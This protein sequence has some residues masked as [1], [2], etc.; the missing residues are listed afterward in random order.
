MGYRG[1]ASLK[2]PIVLLLA[3]AIGYDAMYSNTDSQGNVA[4]GYFALRDS[5]GGS[6]RDYNVAIGYAGM[7][8]GNPHVSVG[9]GV[10]SGQFLKNG[11]VGAIHIGYE[12]GR[13]ASGSYNVSMGYNALKGTHPS[14]NI[15]ILGQMVAITS[16]AINQLIP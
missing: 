11:A 15:A 8:N 10:Y 9:V 5:S 2:Q 12:A 4:I 16:L 14:S 7:R 6:S 13:Y 3:V 1:P